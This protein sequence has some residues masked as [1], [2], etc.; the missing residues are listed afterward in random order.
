MEVEVINK[1]FGPAINKVLE[2]KSNLTNVIFV[3]GVFGLLYLVYR[4]T[5]AEVVTKK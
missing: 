2:P 3:A 5:K 1:L 4:T